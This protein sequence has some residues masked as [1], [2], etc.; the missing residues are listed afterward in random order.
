MTSLTQWTWVWVN[1]GSWRWTGRPG[2][3]RFMGWQRVRHNWATKLKIV[4]AIL[5]LLQFHVNF[6][7]SLSIYKEF[8]WDSDRDCTEPVNEVLEYYHLNNV[9]SFYSWRWGIFSTYLDFFFFLL[10][11]HNILEVLVYNL[12]V[13]HLSV[14]LCCFMTL[15]PSKMLFPLLAKSFHLQSHCWILMYYSK[16]SSSSVKDSMILFTTFLFLDKRQKKLEMDYFFKSNVSIQVVW[17]SG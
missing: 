6:R 11:F 5:V 2:V 9:K 12:I 7:I 17:F 8:I 13:F 16:F 14:M 1:S 3:L 10:S 4:L 15:R